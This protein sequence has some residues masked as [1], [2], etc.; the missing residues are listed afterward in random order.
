MP[1]RAAYAAADADVFPVD[2]HTTTFAPSSAALEIATVIPR[3]LNEPV[4]FA[5]SIFNSTR[6]PTC[7]DSRGASSSGVLPSLSVTIGVR[8]VTGNRSRYA[9]INPRQRGTTVMSSLFPAD[10]A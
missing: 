6:A 2:A 3:S 5:P 8:S 1:A 9:S 4:G 10:D 7:S